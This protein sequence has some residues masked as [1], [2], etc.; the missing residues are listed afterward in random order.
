MSKTQAGGGA[1]E[2][3][4]RLRR[5]ERDLREQISREEVDAA[6]RL[7]AS[8]AETFYENALG[9]NPRLLDASTAAR[10]RI[11]DEGI[12]ATW[13]AYQHYGNPADQLF[14]ASSQSPQSSR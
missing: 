1:H 13:G 11:F 2:V 14:R 8:F 9:P 3:G 6:Q 5:R 7:A 12:G 4:E 10:R